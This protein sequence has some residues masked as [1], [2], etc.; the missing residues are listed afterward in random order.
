MEYLDHEDLSIKGN[1]K[2]FLRLSFL[3][4]IGTIGT[5]LLFF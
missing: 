3:P 2:T 5:V 4:T 1:L